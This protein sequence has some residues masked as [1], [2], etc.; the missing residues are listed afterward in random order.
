MSIGTFSTLCAL[1]VA[2]LLTQA[3]PSSAAESSSIQRDTQSTRLAATLVADADHARQALA[4]NDVTA[5]N[6]DIA[7]ASTARE[8]LV[9]MQHSRG[10]SLIVPLYSE[11]DDTSIFADAINSRPAD[12]A[13]ATTAP[14]T[15]LSNVAQVTYVAIDLNKAKA[16]LDA[17]SL[18]IH[19]KNDQAAKDALAAIGSDLIIGTDTTDVPLVTARED[20]ALA[21]TALKSKQTTVAS[22][23]LLQASSALKRYTNASHSSD[24]Q[25]LAAE[26]EASQSPAAQNQSGLSARIGDW[27]TSVKGWF[28]NHV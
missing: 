18:A 11:L 23:D 15:A 4:A 6:A 10:A 25:R 20:L 3:T 16:R 17:A 14:L 22:A 13:I 9:A 21:R 24:A 19:D 5:A 12:P 8:K 1:A 27:W 7:Q 28:S 26:I 2:T